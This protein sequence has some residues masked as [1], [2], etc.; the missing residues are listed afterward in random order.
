MSRNTRIKYILKKG[1]L[2]HSLGYDE[3]NQWNFHRLDT[4]E[5]NILF[6]P[7]WNV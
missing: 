1:T 2:D 4:S 5:R 7:T 6:H 3:N